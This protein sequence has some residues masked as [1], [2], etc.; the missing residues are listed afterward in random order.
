M[1]LAVGSY[2]IVSNTGINF[3]TSPVTGRVIST[4]RNGDEFRYTGNFQ[5]VDG[6]TWL[7]GYSGTREGWII[8]NDAWY[9]L[10]LRG[11]AI[12]LPATQVDPRRYI[13][14]APHVIG[15][16]AGHTLRVVKG[17]WSGG[18]FV[19]VLQDG[20]RV[21]HPKGS[22]AEFFRFSSKGI[23]RTADTSDPGRP[24]SP[25]GAIYNLNGGLGSKWLPSPMRVG[26]RHQFNYHLRYFGKPKGD[27]IESH[28]DQVQYVTLVAHYPTWRVSDFFDT[29]STILLNDVIHILVQRWDGELQDEMYYS[30]DR[31]ASGLVGWRN[32]VGWYS[33]IDGFAQPHNSHQRAFTMYPVAGVFEMPGNLPILKGTA[34]NPVIPVIP[35]LPAPLPPEPEPIIT[36]PIERMIIESSALQRE[37]LPGNIRGAGVNWERVIAEPTGWS[38]HV[39]RRYENDPF[40]HWNEPNGWYQLE[41]SGSKVSMSL[42]KRG[43]FSIPAGRYRVTMLVS[44]EDFEGDGSDF[45]WSPRF[46]IGGVVYTHE[47][48][49]L[50]R[51]DASVHSGKMQDFVI[52]VKQATTLSSFGIYFHT[53]WA[54][55]KGYYVPHEF[56]LRKIADD[57]D[58]VPLYTLPFVL[59]DPDEPVVPSPDPDEDFD[60]R[61]ELTEGQLNIIN[62]ARD[63]STNHRGAALPGKNL[64]SLIAKLSNL[65]DELTG[66]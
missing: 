21:A 10:K 54:Q 16:S 39:D 42:I 65:L 28:P 31:R 47:V 41:P 57:A 2:E 9:T 22:N 27:E 38:V 13:G 34:P 11:V 45:S 1:A 49:D 56:T 36:E 59:S 29:T 46:N 48:A 26:Q 6:N 3:R 30:A 62:A 44:V 17:D 52:E 12:E 51:W 23:Y 8:V 5:I 24:K 50:P 40:F 55:A 4:L 43:P 33:H 60:W 58:G 15:R 61:E 25:H 64:L 18:E 37:P 66:Q 63:I 32:G 7:R 19:Q 20:G 53:N 35:D 14:M